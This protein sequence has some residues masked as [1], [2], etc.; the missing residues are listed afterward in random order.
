MNDITTNFGEF[1]INACSDEETLNRALEMAVFRINVSHKF[2]L[3][4]DYVDNE[5][6][7]EVESAV[8][9]IEMVQNIKSKMNA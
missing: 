1:N 8:H 7:A 5:D 3:E 2:C 6:I 9:I 4:R